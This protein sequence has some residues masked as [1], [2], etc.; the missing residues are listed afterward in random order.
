MFAR[1]LMSDSLARFRRDKLATDHMSGEDAA[2][3]RIAFDEFF[4]ALQQACA[5]NEMFVPEQSVYYIG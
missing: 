1:V 4:E 3:F 2:K 5:E